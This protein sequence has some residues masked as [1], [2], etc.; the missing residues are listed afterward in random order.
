[1]PDLDG[2]CGVVGGHPGVVVV[3]DVAVHLLPLHP[4]QLLLLISETDTLVA[5]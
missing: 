2:W 4:L 5:H 1:M 3:V